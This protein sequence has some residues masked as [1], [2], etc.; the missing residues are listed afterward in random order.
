[1]ALITTRGYITSLGSGSAG[2][3]PMIESPLNSDL[4]GLISLA[5]SASLDELRARSSVDS[6][7]LAH[8]LAVMLRDGT[9]ALSLTANVKQ[10]ETPAQQDPNFQKLMSLIR[11]P[12]SP[13]LAELVRNHED[14][15]VT[16]IQAALNDDNTAASITVSPTSRGF[17]RSL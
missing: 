11:D 2:I 10:E 7:A 6:T 13:E 16:A 15:L 14:F 17:R 3:Q 8:E 9:V 1:M 12:N 4:F 5:G